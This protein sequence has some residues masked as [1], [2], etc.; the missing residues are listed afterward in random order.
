MY[1]NVKRAKGIEGEREGERE[2]E[3]KNGREREGKEIECSLLFSEGDG[4]L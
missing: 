1:T 4:I 3:D 2:R